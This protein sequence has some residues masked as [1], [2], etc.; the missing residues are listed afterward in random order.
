MTHPTESLLNLIFSGL[1]YNVEDLKTLF[2]VDQP[3]QLDELPAV[4]IGNCAEDLAN[5]HNDYYLVDLSVELKFMFL[6]EGIDAKKKIITLISACDQIVKDTAGAMAVTEQNSG[7]LTQSINREK[8]I[9]T[10]SKTY[11]LQYRR[12]RGL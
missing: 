4:I 7:E 10:C 1:Q 6:D 2:W 5:Y 11:N 12:T 9:L 3:V 8:K